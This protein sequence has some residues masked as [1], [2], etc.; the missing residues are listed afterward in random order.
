MTFS[1]YSYGW[2]ASSDTVLSDFGDFFSTA[3]NNLV[4]ENCDPLYRRNI[5]LSNGILVNPPSGNLEECTL[6][7]AKYTVEGELS[8]IHI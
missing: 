2:A 6:I 1:F 5:Q 3:Y 7:T 8:L 4:D